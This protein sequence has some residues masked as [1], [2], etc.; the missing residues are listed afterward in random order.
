MKTHEID[1]DYDIYPN[2]DWMALLSELN[3]KE[4]PDRFTLD[5]P[6]CKRHEAYIYKKGSVKIYCNRNNKCASIE[7]RIWDY[8]QGRDSLSN[9][10]VFKVLADSAGVTVE[11]GKIN[12]EELEK[13]N[14]KASVLDSF[15]S[16]CQEELKTNK[17]AK[18]YLEGR[19]F[20][21]D[22]ALNL[23]VGFYCRKSINNENL[24]DLNGLLSNQWT[25]RIIGLWG[26]SSGQAVTVWGRDITGQAEKPYY[27]LF[28]QKR[29]RPYGLDNV[30]GNDIIVVEGIID[31]LTLQKHDVQGVVA[32]GGSS[33]PLEHIKALKKARK[34]SVTLNLDN[35]K[36][37]IE[38]MERAVDR[39]E[40]EGIKTYV[41][42]PSLMG[43]A[44][45]PDEFIGKN[46][47]E[48]YNG[49]LKQAQRGIEWR[50]KRL[51]GKHDMQ[52]AKGLD[53]LLDEALGCMDN[54]KDPVTVEYGVKALSATLGI[55]EETLK[56]K[57]DNRR[58]QHR[59]DKIDR[60][61]QDL[62]IKAQRG[63]VDM[64]KLPGCLTE[65]NKE[66]TGKIID[67]L[68]WFDMDKIYEEGKAYSK[69][70][71]ETGI[72]ELD[73][74][75]KIMPKELIIIAGRPGHGKST[76]AYNILLN[77]IEK[78]ED[79]TFVFFNMDVPSTVV[80]TKLATIWAKKKAGDPR[81]KGHGYIS[82]LPSFCDPFKLMPEEIRQ[83][84]GELHIYGNKKRLALVNK[85]R[86]TVE[87]LINHA[88]EIGKNK[89]LGA[90]FI[91]YIGLLDT[92]KKTDTEELKLSCIAKNLRIASE[93]LSC[94][95]F[96][97]VQLNRSGTD[98]KKP[99]TRRPQLS[100][101]RYSGQQE[102]EATTVLGLFNQAQDGVELKEEETAE[103][104]L[105]S[106]DEAITTLEII[107]LKNRGGQSNKTIRTN[108]EMKTGL[109]STGG[110]KKEP[111]QY[112]ET[113]DK[114]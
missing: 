71:K 43:D 104:S 65:L 22:Q 15:L 84:F 98:G 40:A 6:D 94:P 103:T 109:I 49:L 55:N 7:P 69:G 32:S 24:G 114:K 4:K 36:A 13:R 44:K 45:D 11:A 60:N 66:R 97:L 35:D 30:H 70:G 107:T 75:V 82:L 2:I 56:E 12:T 72:E 46:N 53:D 52:T 87:Q 101:L 106:K 61:R 113:K 54:L 20:T 112:V 9:P 1:L 34:A 5:C 41:I 110:I 99:T 67:D 58:E 31:C 78:Y 28:G 21:L 88:K 64:E 83:A 100:Q 47:I 108:F 73:R 89:K 48:A 81:Y 93:E 10:E 63:E 111:G 26:D 37:G 50:M 19:G 16:D 90:I 59:L 102:Q 85:P 80:T 91:D 8:I 68:G 51:E 77:F 17:A 18:T 57:T 25:D 79:E 39:L 74:I 76:L 27:Y 23:G 86:Y 105:G 38:G 29:D 62:L 92:E 14:K 95:V 33:L 96:V 42:E 3:P